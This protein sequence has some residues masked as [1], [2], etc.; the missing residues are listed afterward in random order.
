MAI[1][2]ME[3]AKEY[4]IGDTD[5]EGFTENE[6]WL[7]EIGN[8]YLPSSPFQLPLKRCRC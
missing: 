6:D 5:Q 1:E 3:L 7:G 8:G 4:Y 2:E